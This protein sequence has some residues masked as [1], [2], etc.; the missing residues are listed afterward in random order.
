MTTR[1]VTTKGG[2]VK[3]VGA[4][5]FACV[6]VRLA[7]AARHLEHRP[8]L[9][10]VRA[11][12]RHDGRE[13]CSYRLDSGVN[14][15]PDTVALSQANGAGGYGLC[16]TCRE[17]D[18]RTMELVAMRDGRSFDLLAGGSPLAAGMEVRRAEVPAACAAARRERRSEGRLR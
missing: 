15:V 11:M 14:F 1:V 8:T 4:L 3:F 12:A 5:R 6:M 10:E 16:F 13:P 9:R 7:R 18:G 17:A 2:S